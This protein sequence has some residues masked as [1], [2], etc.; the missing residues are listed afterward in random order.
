MSKSP[1]SKKIVKNQH[2]LDE[3]QLEASGQKEVKDHDEHSCCD[4]P[5]SLCINPT[6]NCDS[7]IECEGTVPVV[8]NCPA[9]TIF[10]PYTKVCVPGWTTIY[11]CETFP[12]SSPR[13]NS[14]TI[15]KLTD[16]SHADT[17]NSQNIIPNTRFVHEIPH[18]NPNRSDHLYGVLREAW[19]NLPQNELSIDALIKDERYPYFPDEYLIMDMF[20]APPNVGDFYGQRLSSYYLAAETG[21]YV[22]YL[23]CDDE[24]ELW[25][26]KNTSENSLEKV[27]YL[28]TNF[29]TDFRE[30][31]RYPEYQATLYIQFEAD[32]FY[33]MEAFMRESKY[34]DHLSVGVLKP[35][36]KVEL[37]I[38]Q[39][40]YLIPIKESV[41]KQSENNDSV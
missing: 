9:E 13:I 41:L 36:G 27:A 2:R 35:G 11:T 40:L 26:G 10:D 34:S 6:G 3:N 38:S 24:C 29:S 12:Q 14:L 4:I 30:W 20:E 23:S 7:F 22:F 8:K 33:L 15:G 1:H 5:Y 28:P 37:P 19:F 25:I 21:P 32:N 17:I 31:N 18:I 16:N 39:N